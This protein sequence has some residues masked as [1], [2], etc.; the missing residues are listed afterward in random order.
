MTGPSI[1]LGLSKPG[2]E[3]V[4]EM[5]S[6]AT[7]LFSDTACPHRC[8]TRDEFFRAVFAARFARNHF[9]RRYRAVMGLSLFTV[10][11]RIRRARQA[12]GR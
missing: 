6:T 10:Q 1:M 9:L 4:L 11:K 7:F 2:P 3:D 8:T 5:L 12:R